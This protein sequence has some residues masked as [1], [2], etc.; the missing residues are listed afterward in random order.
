MFGI[1]DA[2]LIG[3]GI[4]AIAGLASGVMSWMG[5]NAQADASLEAAKLQNKGTE[6]AVQLQRDQY[7]QTRQDLE[8]FRQVSQGALNE[9][10]SLE[11]FSFGPDQFQQDPGYSFRLAEGMKAIQNS[12]AAR[13][14]LLSGN[15]LKAVQRYGQEMGSQEY[16]N[17]FNRAQ[18]IYNSRLNKLQSLAGIGQTAVGD[19][20]RAGENF[21]NNV[22]NLQVAGANALAGGYT[23]A[24]NAR[25]S[26]YVGTANALNNALANSYNNY[27]NQQWVNKLLSNRTST[28]PTPGAGYPLPY[29]YEQG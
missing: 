10:G 23:G 24:A 20:G 4:P 27:Q 8:P 29:Q 7:T 13:G 6:A 1:D 11:P 21:A 19:L 15:T 26:G 17:A 3:V 9:I 16:Q 28:P 2:L 5:G 22:G 14:G 25:T 12:A 18:T